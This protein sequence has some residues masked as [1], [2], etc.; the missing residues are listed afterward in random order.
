MIL[1]LLFLRDASS[2]EHVIFE[3]M[4]LVEKKPPKLDEKTKRE[5]RMGI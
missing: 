2:D 1:Q 3:I 5:D 4:A